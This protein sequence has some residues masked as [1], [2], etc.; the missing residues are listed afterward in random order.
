MENEGRGRQCV[1]RSYDVV[2]VVSDEFVHMH[3]ICT[4]YNII[5]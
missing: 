1:E 5:S 4:M 3:K 2:H